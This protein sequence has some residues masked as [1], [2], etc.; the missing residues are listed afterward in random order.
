MLLLSHLSC[1][2]H[3]ISEGEGGGDCALRG[4]GGHNGGDSHGL[5]D[6]N[7]NIDEEEV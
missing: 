6:G 7:S 3:S 2:P 5:H 4:D 1:L